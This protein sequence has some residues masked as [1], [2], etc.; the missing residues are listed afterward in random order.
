M[1]TLEVSKLNYTLYNGGRLAAGY[2]V[3]ANKKALALQVSF[4]DQESDQDV[5]RPKRTLVTRTALR[6][7]E[8]KWGCKG[9]SGTGNRPLKMFSNN[10]IL[11]YENST[12]LTCFH[13]EHF[14]SLFSDIFD[15][16]K[17]TV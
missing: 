13:Q 4:H 16:F 7:R 12:K 5:S 8:H 11:H 3:R 10:T 9:K 6:V 2:A 17:S 14:I 1:T 15:C